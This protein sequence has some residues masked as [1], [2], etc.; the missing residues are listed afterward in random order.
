MRTDGV[1]LTST[2]RRPT[3][4]VVKATKMLLSDDR[5]LLWRLDLARNWRVSI[6]AGR[7]A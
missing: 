4:A 3:I 7:L 2:L 5:T 6:E 1:H